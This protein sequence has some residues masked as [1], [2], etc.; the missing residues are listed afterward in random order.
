MGSQCGGTRITCSANAGSALPSG[1]ITARC[2]SPMKRVVAPSTAPFKIMV[3]QD[4]APSIEIVKP[5]EEEI[6][7]PANGQLAVDATVVDDIG[8]DKL[9]LKMRLAE[10]MKGTAYGRY[11]IRQAGT[12]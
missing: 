2:S 8:I 4:Q 5:V 12:R 6:A 11:L 7:L 9:T 3:D 1:A 10:P